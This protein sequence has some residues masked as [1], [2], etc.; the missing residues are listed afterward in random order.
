[1]TPVHA[2]DPPNE[3]KVYINVNK[4]DAKPDTKPKF[5]EIKFALAELNA[6]LQRVMNTISLMLFSFVS[7][8]VYV[9]LQPRRL[10]ERDNS[11][12]ALQF[13]TQFQIELEVT[14][15]DNII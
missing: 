10:R 7:I 11:V 8:K 15:V 3:V 9:L 14:I 2:S 5:K 4:A 12:D 6:P 1:M 13:H